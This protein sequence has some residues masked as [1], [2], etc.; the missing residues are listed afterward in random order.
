MALAG[1][2]SSRNV[3]MGSSLTVDGA[4]S[5]L[6]VARVTGLT[7]VTLG[8][9]EGGLLVLPAGW[10]P[11]W[12]SGVV[13]G[14]S[15][16]GQIDN[17]T[18]LSPGGIS[19]AINTSAFVNHGA[20]DPQAGG[21][22]DFSGSFRVDDPG[23]LAGV[24]GGLITVS[25]DLLGNTANAAGY[26]P[27]VTVR[28]DGAGTP[29][30]PQLL[31]VMGE[32]LSDRD[33]GFVDNFAH[34]TIELA[35]STY[36]QLVDLSDN[37][38]GD[39]PEALYVHS[40]IVPA[41]TTLDL[42]GYNVYCR[43]TQITGHI[44]KSNGGELVQI[45]DSGSLVQGTPTPGEISEAGQL[46][47]WHFFGQKDLLATVAVNPGTSGIAPPL[48][49]RLG[50]AEVT[51]LDADDNILATASGTSNG[52]TV[53]LS[54]V[55]LPADGTYRIQI[56]AAAGHLA[57]TG[58][59][60]VTVYDVTPDVSPILL[61]QQ[62]FGQI[63]NPYSV[64][65]WEF[66]A[67]ANT[68][69]RFDLLAMASSNI[70]FDLTLPD[71][72]TPGG[73]PLWTG[74][75]GIGADSGLVTLPE[76][77]EYVLTARGLAVQSGGSYSFKLDQTTVSDLAIGTPHTGSFIGS[78]QAELFRIDVPE[79]GPMK[80]K[81]D[82]AATN[83]VNELYLKFGTPPTRGDYD[84]RFN[85]AS[86][87]DQQIL[88][89]S[90]YAGTWYALVYSNT[91][92]T[93]STYE[94]AA[95]TADV[96]IA[97]ITPDR[98]ATGATVTMT[99]SGAGF[100]ADTDV[101]LVA[102]G[103]A[104]HP[105]AD[106]VVESNTRLTVTFDLTGI[107]EALYSV[108]VSKP[109]AVADTL[110]DAFTVLPPGPA[111]LQTRLV[112]PSTLG[113]HG[114]GTFYV[115]YANVGNEAMPT[116]LL[117][118]ESADPDGRER[119]FLTL[120]RSRLVAGFWTSAMP[121]G[122]ANSV[123]F[124][125]IGETPGVLQP[126]ESGR[127]PVYY[128]GMQQ[129][130]DF[131]DR[132]FEFRVGVLAEASLIVAD[133]ASLKDQM[134]PNYV[135][136]DAWD[137]VWSNFTSQVGTT[138][139]GYLAALN[140]NAVFLDR[141][142]AST[143][144]MTRL[145]AFELRQADGLNPIRYLA[146]GTDAA[147]TAPG[148]DLVFSRAYA[149]PI[150][151]RYETGPLGRGWAHNWQLSLVREAD[152]TV[153]IT[154]MTGTP[155]IFQP[156]SRHAGQYFAGPGD[157][158]VLTAVG[159]GT[160]GLREMDGTTYRFRS[161]GLL[162][163]V[164]DT[165][166]NR[167]TCGYTAG[168]LTALTHSSGQSIAITYN[169]AN[170]V[171][172]V[173]DP[174]GRTARYTYDAA[175]EHLLSVQ[176]YDGRTSTYSYITGQGIT[177]EHA[178]SEIA[179]PGGTHRYYA[180][181]ARGRLAST[182]RDGGAEMIV[183]AYDDT[184]LVTATDAL[185]NPS[186]FYF[187]DWG[188]I[189]KGTNA[190]GNSVL[191]TLDDERN[192]E[193]VT[194]PAGHSHLFEY[195]SLGN[196]TEYRDAMGNATGFT[197]T[198]DF[199][200]L[201]LLTDAN[202]NVTDYD[203]DAS[204]NLT[205]IT[206]ADDSAESWSYDGLGQATT[207][208]NRRSTPIG[209]TYNADGQITRKTYDDGSF[210]DYVYDARGNLTEA[211]DSTGTTTFTYDTD[212]YLTRIDYPGGQ[213]LEFTYDAAGRRATSLDQLGHSLTYS[214]DAAGRLSTITDE[215]ATQIVLY[216]Y[217]AVGR[218][219]R[220]ALGNGVYTT[221]DYDPAGQLLH[222]VNC[223]ADGT[224][225]SRFDYTYDSR[226]RRTGMDTL[227]G[228]WTYEYDDVGQL[229]H[230]VFAPSAGSTV[231]AQ[232]LLYVYD[233]MGNRVYTIENGVRTDYTTN[234]L[235]QYTRTV[236]SATGETTYTF[237][238]DGNLVS[239][240]ST[241]GTTTYSYDDENRL[242]AVQDGTDAWSYTY[243]AFS[244][245]VATDYN[246][247][248]TEYLIDPIGL[249]NVVGEYDAV[250]NLI[251]GYDHGF[252]LLSQTVDGASNWYTFDGIGNTVGLL[253]ASG[254]ILNSYVYEPFGSAIHQSETTANPFQFVGEWGVMDEGNGLGFMRARY[255]LRE[256]GRFTQTDPIG[257]TA[258]PNLYAY[259]NNN[260]VVQVDPS[261]LCPDSLSKA[262]R[263]AT[264]SLGR[265]V[266]IGLAATAVGGVVALSSPFWG[267]VIIIGGIAYT[268]WSVISGTH[269]Y[270][271][272]TR[273]I[274]EGGQR[275]L[276][277]NLGG[278][279]LRKGAARAQ[280]AGGA[281]AGAQG[282]SYCGPSSDPQ[283]GP[284]VPTDPNSDGTNNGAN[285]NDP[286]QKLGPAGYGTQVFV[287]ANERFDYRIDFE[288]DASATAPAQIVLISDTLD[289]NFDRSTFELTEIGFG[290]IL[291]AI[292][293]GSQYYQT[294]VPFTYDG[295]TFNV[296]IEAG[297]NLAPGEVYAAFYA[298]DPATGLPP[299]GV[300]GF[301]PP[302]DGTG[303][304]MGHVSYM[305]QTVPG[306]PTGTEIRN[307]AHITFDGAMTIPTNAVDPLDPAKGTDPEKEALVTIDAGLPSSHLLP[308]SETT[309]GRQIQLEWSGEDD[310]NGSGIAHYDIYVSTDQGPWELWLS[311]SLET[312]AVYDGAIGHSY[313]FYSV[314]HDNVGHVEQPPDEADAVT[315]V[316]A[317]FATVLD[318][319]L[320]ASHWE[321]S[322]RSSLAA[323]GM[324]A[325]GISLAT[326]GGHGGGSIP[327]GGIDVIR[328]NFDRDV[329]VGA[330][331][332]AIY[333]LHHAR[334]PTEPAGFAYDPGTFTATWH[335]ATPIDLDKIMLHLSDDI[336]DMNGDPLDGEGPNLPSGNDQAG[337]DLM[338]RCD[339]LA[340]DVNRDGVVAVS[341]IGGMRAAVG[342]SA[343]DAGYSA[344]AD[345][346]GN[347]EVTGADVNHLRDHIGG[348]MPSG[349]PGTGEIRGTKWLDVNGNGVRETGLLVDADPDVVFVIDVSGSTVT[350]FEGTPVGDVNGDGVT[351]DAL[352]AELAGFIALNQQ[353]VDLGF[354]DSAEVSVIVFGSLAASQDMDPVASGI[355]LATSPVA[356]RDANGIP[357]V[358]EA[359]RR[360]VRG[361]GGT[362]L[363]TNFEAALQEAIRVIEM[364][365][366]APSNPN[367]IF[368]SDGEDSTD[369]SDEITTLRALVD[370]L[371]AFGAGD[372]ADLQRLQEIDPLARI[373]TTTDELLEVFAGA[374]ETSFDEPGLEG[375]TIYLDLNDDGQLD[376]GE[377]RTVTDVNGRY[378]L[379]DVEPG[380]YAV[381]EVIPDG[382][383]QTFPVATD[384]RSGAHV[385][386]LM[387]Q[388]IRDDVDFG[389]RE[390]A[391]APAGGEIVSGVA[392]LSDPAQERKAPTRRQLLRPAMREEAR[393]AAGGVAEGLLDRSRD[394]RSSTLD[395]WSPR[396]E[397]RVAR[398]LERIGL[399]SDVDARS[400]A[401]G[402]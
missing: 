287:N 152:G 317:R 371:R 43:A 5:V 140:D 45:P 265:D 110:P 189:L 315:I 176:E 185:G 122:F 87:A 30:A 186:Q 224:V 352:D 350:D 125:A 398:W 214:Y 248:I 209:F 141:L 271:N 131:G 240:A 128:A 22:L 194:D 12:G 337:G 103:G 251:A 361:H 332:L 219:A 348:Q 64:D 56:R 272:T 1:A 31:E 53:S 23:I 370:N 360:I 79:S 329:V 385:V 199:N 387:M 223:R 269:S 42:N 365:G 359:L 292:P 61:N 65:L 188:T 306:L 345:L 115:E 171:A 279:I 93:T 239:E 249:G 283:N 356:D 158:G 296:E 353:L 145:L 134:Q 328:V 226:G 197:Y 293:A 397:G 367:V 156:D 73:E 215:S 108:Q 28:F 44:D 138:W 334:Y 72:A 203:Y 97:G 180:Y 177:R 234:S 304:G 368:M 181:D 205:S 323:A 302:E 175:N 192:L 231:P 67:A 179:Y 290:D 294:A 132:R 252:G 55:Q 66:S 341:D 14:T 80:I 220:K 13:L 331:D 206:Y 355:Q 24:P 254:A 343:G 70:V 349:V 102:P 260:P 123:Q 62:V 2:I 281:A 381:R 163:Y 261:G 40:L 6:D 82:D 105:A 124:V 384:G 233:A 264:L 78:G 121:A 237:D 321:E 52:Q 278:G 395:R 383:E 68:Q 81:L 291:L 308:L 391:V 96:Q 373:F 107:P 351:N 309:L 25:G 18:A 4:D 74:F 90:A 76:A 170:R 126:G 322:F 164:E 104:S 174:D 242:I 17:R 363:D 7:T 71:P 34:S 119:P 295:Q 196:L 165:N 92:R 187:D 37:A 336:A 216:E 48:P 147:A 312:S 117:V 83:N 207:W 153:K 378:A 120:D 142:G 106:I 235:N 319:S 218:I 320:G 3:R 60:T 21:V 396:A 303:R 382:S 84:Y 36:V 195:D 256:L 143:T 193:S 338:F 284:N 266:A 369:I 393:R 139:G 401:A 162:D 184:G 376:D 344:F 374:G 154:D 63:E 314:A 59:Y 280:P 259:V 99:V 289:A 127:V 86:A 285:A 313:G 346:D 146:A 335:L 114:T 20:L 11:T 46:D 150:S 273:E 300:S 217:D 227:D 113:Y 243:D 144:E 155:R 38:P 276:Q 310:V 91:T 49:P 392:A 299:E 168:L 29:D 178:L 109:G 307:I 200:R 41:G 157:H 358:E 316:E 167:I 47:E 354:G 213:F 159:G 245:R 275:N 324:G 347:G 232:D 27:L 183:F 208:T 357:D 39:D 372:G 33:E 325:D 298:I 257:V 326:Y 51:L 101:A 35:G 263:D 268:G 161:E 26:A 111:E 133:W 182:S 297:I 202:G 399:I 94:L 277:N 85:T 172:S 244:Q 330:D 210:V 169:A 339:V 118:L 267:G 148:M 229:T 246:G 77:G 98:Y 191:L 50:Y 305:I 364:A 19:L 327:W 270:T 247:D 241:A 54:N 201:D 318:I 10:Q 89:P 32:E 151:R 386:T 16:T 389:N 388:E 190:L 402:R 221:Y 204:G 255:Y 274:M 166:G 286:N 282:S 366:T 379:T 250:G 116:P 8:A 137:A 342:Y 149:Q 390:A 222:L 380:T 311:R 130:W 129:P 15:G 9:G 57:N 362:G 377:R 394:R 135:Q 69:I 400:R 333:G 95:T 75:D 230:A 160:Y 258:G 100:D 228:L 88:V 173:T 225:L 198:A 253:D 236:S 211:T 112:L 136:A 301:L 58:N 238:A 288:N 212:D 262:G 340:G 375:V